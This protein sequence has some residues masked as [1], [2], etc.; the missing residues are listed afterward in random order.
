MKHQNLWFLCYL[1][2]PTQLRCFMA[3]NLYALSCSYDNKTQLTGS[4]PWTFLQFFSLNIFS[5]GFYWRAIRHYKFPLPHR[6]EAII[7]RCQWFEWY[8]DGPLIKLI[9]TRCLRMRIYWKYLSI[10]FPIAIFFAAH[11]MPDVLLTIL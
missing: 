6:N 7:D 9:Y 11:S 5:E 10:F 3:L 4:A 1:P 8:L 2:S